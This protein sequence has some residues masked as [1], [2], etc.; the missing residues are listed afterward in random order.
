MLHLGCL[1]ELVQRITFRDNH[2]QGF[3][4]NASIPKSLG[5]EPCH[6]CSYRRRLQDDGI[7]GC[8]TCDDTTTQYGTREVPR[9]DD[10]HRV[11]GLDID[12][13]EGIEF[14]HRRGVE[15][16]VVNTL[17]HFYIAFFNRLTR[18]GTHCANLITAHITQ[19]VGGIV[20]NLMTLLDGCVTPMTRILSSNLQ[21][22]FHLTDISPRHLADLHV[23][24]LTTVVI[25][26]TAVIDDGCCSNLRWDHLGLVRQTL[27]PFLE[28]VTLP[29]LVALTVE[30]S[31]LLVDHHIGR[32]NGN[33]RLAA[34]LRTERSVVELILDGIGILK[35]L[36]QELPSLRTRLEV[37][38]MAEEVARSCVLVHTAHEIGHG[39]EK[40]LVMHD[41][42]IEH[43]MIA[44]LRLRTPYV[45]CH[46]LEHLKAEGVL[47]CLVFLRQQIS[48]RD[49][50]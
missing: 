36:L 43:H 8:Q 25:L 33:V 24:V 12:I 50:I 39:I 28:D 6:R 18:N 3:L 22:L 40:L 26:V 30:I 21:Y 1:R 17:R 7:A 44:N 31:I 32:R 20:H 47:R 4:R 46:T 19:A 38:R 15:T 29:L 35:L 10:K 11:L 9:R 5:K 27:L 14:L 49:G 37:E 2:L 34:V 48:I 45:I 41:R 13:T 42:S 23:L 16:T